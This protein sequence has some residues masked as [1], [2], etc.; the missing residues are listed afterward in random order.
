MW[1]TLSTFQ[2]YLKTHK[3]FKKGKSIEQLKTMSYHWIIRKV[4]QLLWMPRK[5]FKC[6][7]GEA[8]SSTTML[9]ANDCITSIE[10]G[11]QT[12]LL[13]FEWK[14]LANPNK[15]I[16]IDDIAE[17]HLATNYNLWILLTIL[18]TILTGIVTS[19]DCVVY[20][21]KRVPLMHFIVCL[22][23][24]HRTFYDADKMLNKNQ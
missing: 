13:W 10:N 21:M 24:C 5:C 14:V 17:I 11:T 19:R 6:L 1:S 4:R 7:E 8:Q 16:I 22:S 12:C 23:S 2:M 9:I 20:T 18:M 15:R 3:Q